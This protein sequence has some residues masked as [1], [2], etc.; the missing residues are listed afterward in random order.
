MRI[1]F[2]IRFW[3]EVLNKKGSSSEESGGQNSSNGSVKAGGVGKFSFKQFFRCWIIIGIWKSRANLFSHSKVIQ[4]F[5]LLFCIAHSRFAMHLS[6]ITKILLWI[7]FHLQG[8]SLAINVKK[9]LCGRNCENGISFCRLSPS[10]IIIRLILFPGVCWKLN[11]RILTLVFWGV[12]SP[13]NY[14]Q[15]SSNQQLFEGNDKDQNFLFNE[16]KM[17]K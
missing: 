11:R 5:S 3:A 16:T 14:A 8:Q 7:L 12:E 1:S 13:A 10:Q 17:S 9:Q 6:C 15:I 4:P 2:S